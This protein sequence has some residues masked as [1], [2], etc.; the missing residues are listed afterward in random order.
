MSGP[1]RSPPTS[2]EDAF[3]ALWDASFDTYYDCFYYEAVSDRLVNRW[4]L[5]DDVTKV[6]VAVTAS[7]SALSG[8][9]LW[10]H[11]GYKVVWV[12]LAGFAAGLAIVHTTLAVTFRL[13][14]W[15]EIKR[16]F[17]SLRVELETLR[18]RMEFDAD[19]ETTDLRRDFVQ[20]RGR[21][22]DVVLRLRNDS[23][24]TRRLKVS[25]QEEVD[26]QTKAAVAKRPKPQESEDVQ[27]PSSPAPTGPA[28]APSSADEG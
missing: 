2:D 12:T 20:A 22:R 5:A 3:K 26:R 1:S 27:P 4:Q 9:T 13:R 18:Y 17:A 15:G 11:P 14:D 19:A 7:G 16:G 28:S 24:L 23:L 8:W 25:A 6:L 10:S 21:Y